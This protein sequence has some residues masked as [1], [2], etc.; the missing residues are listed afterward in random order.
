M[1]KDLLIG[2]GVS[3]ITGTVGHGFGLNAVQTLC[4]T[5]PAFLGGVA[6]M[7]PRESAA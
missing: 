7:W 5:I 1:G 3:L 4:L 2:L 6:V